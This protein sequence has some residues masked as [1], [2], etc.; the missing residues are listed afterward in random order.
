M[1]KGD[2]ARDDAGVEHEIVDVLEPWEQRYVVRS[3]GVETAVAEFDMFD[4][5]F[6]PS[7][8]PEPFIR[9]HGDTLC[10]SC[11]A[12]YRRHPYDPAELS[13]DGRPFLRVLCDGT[14][15]KL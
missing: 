9:A 5:G 4:L 12:G 1:K 7:S 13:F 15:V 6:Q 11:R 3:N 14:R 8:R 2:R 10:P